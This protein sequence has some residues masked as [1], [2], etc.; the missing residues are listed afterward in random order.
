MSRREAAGLV[1]EHADGS[2]I[3]GLKVA[4]W[5]FDPDVAG[6]GPLADATRPLDDDDDEDYD[7]DE[8][9]DEDFDE[10]FEEDLDEDF[11]EDEDYDEDFDE[12]VDLDAGF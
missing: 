1:N 11:D 10:D 3:A 4:P 12:D 7:L 2:D 5:W 8:D 9:L 6:F